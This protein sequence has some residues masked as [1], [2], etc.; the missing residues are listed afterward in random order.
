[1]NA[2]KFAH[3]MRFFLLLIASGLFLLSC[4][5]DDIL[6]EGNNINTEVPKGKK[7]G[8]LIINEA[9]VIL[10]FNSIEKIRNISDNLVIFGS[11]PV[12]AEEIKVGAILVGAKYDGSSLQNIMGKVTDVNILNG[13]WHVSITPI[14]LE[15]FIYSGTI[16]GTVYPTS[17]PESALKNADIKDMIVL[18]DVKGFPSYVALNEEIIKTR[19]LVKLPRLEYSDTYTIP[20]PE[21]PVADFKSS[22]SL[23]AGFTPAF[24][25]TIKFGLF[26]GLKEFNITLYAQDILLDASLYAQAGLKFDL[27]PDDLYTI[28]IAPI[29]LGPTGLILSPT[30][31]AGP[32]INLEAA[33]NMNVKLF[34]AEGEISY[35]LTNPTQAPKFNVKMDPY[36]W[37]N[38]QWGGL[39]AKA[40]GGLYCSAGLSLTFI[41]TN[42]ATVGASAKVGVGTTVEMKD[43]SKVN[44]NVYGRVN[45]DARLALGVWPLKVEK[46]FP[47]ISWTPTIYAKDFE[48]GIK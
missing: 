3:S 7:V 36:D 26:T 22:V 28:P 48:T 15:E 19:A 42:I 29:A 31:S 9:S 24:D 11:E 6:D 17:Y 1:M 34:H 5:Q 2:K 16:S 20:I 23:T 43:L 39:Y 8:D 40:E 4:N 13:E 38:I 33:T 37:S 14:P 44:L 25:Y 10:D 18:Q 12:E 21:L 32:Y 41:A 46:T 35:V 47:I 45:A 27:Y 30:I